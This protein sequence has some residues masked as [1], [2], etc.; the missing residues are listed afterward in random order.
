[1]SRKG[2]IPPA[3]RDWYEDFDEANDAQ[4]GPEAGGTTR[5]S[6]WTGCGLTLAVLVVLGLIWIA[7][8][9]EKEKE[10]ARARFHRMPSALGSVVFAPDGQTMALGRSDGGVVIES[11]ADGTDREIEAGPGF[12]MLPRG[13]SYSPDGKLLASGGRG[14]PV[15]LWDVASGSLR[16]SLEG[17]SKPV[18]SLAF[19]PD[20]K[21]LASGSLDGSIKLWDVANGREL[22][23]TAGH[24]LDI[25]G[26]AFSPDGKMLASGSLDGTVKLWDVV[27]GRELTHVQCGDQRVYGLAFAPDGKSLALGLSASAGESKGEVVLWNPADTRQPFRFLGAASFASVAFSPDGRTVAA[28][29][30]DRLVK[31][32]DVETGQELASLTGHEGFIASLAFSPDGQTLVT[33]GHD[34][35]VG[36]FEFDPTRLKP[37]THSL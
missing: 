30:G 5:V 28:A 7:R 23:K 6:A 21:L 34:T 1:M 36:L 33:A 22:V 18:A 13:L 26:L 16:A 35:F 29:G 19:S 24:S 37:A 11:L 14:L 20:G 8:E 12:G 9:P 3:E 32:W 2:R 10:K 31:L 17:H 25:R 15:K 4:A 27:S